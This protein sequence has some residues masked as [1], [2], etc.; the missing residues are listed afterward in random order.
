MVQPPAEKGGP[1]HSA[2]ILAVDEHGNVAVILHSCNGILWGAT[3]IF[4]DGISIPDSAVFQQRAIA[5]AGPGVRL[6]ES[7]NPLLVLKGGKPVLASVAIGS[8]LHD[9]TLENLINV[10]DFGMDPETSVNQPN[11]RGPYMGVVANASGKPEYEK[12]AIGEGEFSQS[13]LDGVEARGQPI[14][15]VPKY[16]QPGYWIGIQIDPS[17]HK[18]KGATTPLLPALVESY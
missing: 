6:P 7:T 17:A 14:K 9:A 12:E 11:T 18:L 3:G 8:A 1:G 15:L 2:G 5:E 16:G 10:L 13:V 4:V